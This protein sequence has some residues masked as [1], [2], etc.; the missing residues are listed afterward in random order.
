MD[1]LRWTL[2]LQLTQAVIEKDQEGE[3]DTE[4]GLGGERRRGPGTQVDCQEEGR[5]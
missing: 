1:T 3:K 4:A 5:L 2:T